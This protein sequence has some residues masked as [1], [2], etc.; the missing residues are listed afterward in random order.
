MQSAHSLHLDVLVSGIEGNAPAVIINTIGNGGSVCAF[1]CGEIHSSGRGGS[2]TCAQESA[3]R[4][5]VLTQLHVAGL[6]QLVTKLSDQI[7]PVNM[8]RGYTH[9]F[10]RF[11]P[12]N[13]ARRRKS[14]LGTQ[15]YS[16]VDRYGWLFPIGW[17]LSTGAIL[18][19][20]R[21]VDRSKHLLS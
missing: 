19:P 13:R 18:F 11:A 4:L 5:R 9:Y 1:R 6:L 10:S 21:Q 15:L 12:H 3:W 16:Q 14:R 17:L 8:T 20:T 2:G 7:H